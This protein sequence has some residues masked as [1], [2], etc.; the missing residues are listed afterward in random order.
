MADLMDCFDNYS[1]S[2]LEETVGE[3]FKINY[4]PI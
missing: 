3:N 2:N 1:Y 4:K